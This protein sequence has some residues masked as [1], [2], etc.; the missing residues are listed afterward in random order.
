MREHA[1]GK[2]LVFRVAF[3]RRSWPMLVARLVGWPK[4]VVVLS[5][6][7]RSQNG[8]CRYRQPFSFLIPFLNFSKRACRRFP[9]KDEMKETRWMRFCVLR[10]PL[11]G[12]TVLEAAQNCML[13]ETAGI[14]TKRLSWTEIFMLYLEEIRAKSCRSQRFLWMSRTSAVSCLRVSYSRLHLPF[15]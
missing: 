9:G 10:M 6:Q 15:S 5:V 2:G 4:A 14:G 1:E 11:V 7:G 12:S 3:F 13:V 8:K